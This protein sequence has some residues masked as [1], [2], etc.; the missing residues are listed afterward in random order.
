LSR[1]IG[2]ELDS[3]I[4]EAVARGNDPAEAR[5]AFG[6][7]LRYGEESRNIRVM[8]WLDSLRADAVFGW[9]QL[10]KNKV[11]SGAAI[12]S[13]ALGIGACT[14][15]SRLIDALLLRPLPVADPG[16]LYA[17]S[18][19]GTGSD[20]APNE[21]DSCSYPMFRQWRDA[22]KDR[23]EL[24]AA[25][26]GERMDLTYRSDR[27]M[28]KAH[29]QYV[30]GWMFASFGLRPTLGRLLTERDDLTPDAHPYGVLSYG[31]WAS[32]FAR[33]PGAIGRTFRMGNNL[34]EIVGVGPEG[35]TG[36]EPGIMADIFVPMT[37]VGAR[38]IGSSNSFW[39]RTFVRPKPGVPINPLRG[40]L[41][42]TYRAF[43]RE[44]A[45]TFTNFPKRLLEGYPKDKLLL[46]PAGAG[47]S[48]LQQDYRRALAALG[49]LVALVLLIACA[50]VANLT[51]AQAAARAREMALR[52]SIGAGRW[53]LVQLVLTE[54]ALLAFLAAAAGE[55]FAWRSAPFVVGLINPADNP[56]RLSLP[57]DWRM[58]GF[59]L[60]LA[61]AVML[62]FGLAPALRAS[63]V[64]PVLALKGGDDPR[65]RRRLMHPL[66]ALQVAFC[67][68]VV[69][70][71]GLFV[72]TFERLANQPT[73]FSSDRLLVLETVAP[74]PQ[75]PVYWDQLAGGLR[76]FPGVERIALAAWP[77]L[78]GT[79]SNNFISIN[80]APPSTILTYFLGVS[81][82]WLETMKIP[83]MDGRDFRA[84]DAHPGVAIVNE[85]F[86]EAY[87]DGRDPVGRSFE[88]TAAGPRPRFQIV[89]WVKDA[90][91][92]DMREPMLPVA[93]VPFQS[94]DTAGAWK[95]RSSAAI[96]VR[97]SHSDSLALAPALRQA[98]AQAGH[99]F[100]VGNIRTQ[101][102]INEAHTVRE[103]LLAMLALFF[104]GVA[105]LLAGVGLYGVPDYSVLQRRRE[106]GIRM[107]IGAQVGLIAR[108]VTVEIFT[109]VL[110]GAL[111]GL[112]LGLASVRYIAALLYQVKPADPA[113][114]ALPLLTILAAAL[115]A[116]LPAVFHALRIDPAAMLR[117]E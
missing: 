54:S 30:S 111:A 18:F 90:R 105:L 63:A 48:A 80:G 22:V 24:L 6:S 49:V 91:Y 98:V 76:E 65:A 38:T 28:E 26:Y 53:R 2:E 50:N 39:F 112:A 37:M 33:D 104:A 46:R 74:Q 35:F 86:A 14:A 97:A 64:Q 15:A 102:E 101:K 103:R 60:A 115:L 52:V 95:P 41:Y 57:A 82:G 67:F 29:V 27:E 68:V 89:G 55:L 100:R 79:Q 106:I 83:L 1:D 43:E 81:P 69:F 107:A 84:G 117:A 13:L 96:L 51:T 87:F 36:T 66:I 99:G 5:R 78:S 19:E 108:L 16:R 47:V 72:S 92:Q 11:A 58:V 25:S 7:A 23:A 42:A 116:A 94:V 56:A 10:M 40:K 113:M 8:P 61:F 17:I 110:A 21:Y 31:Y 20:G 73:G 71:S 45:K 88:T 109:M 9:R 4:A 114:L 85:T 62:L 34:Y 44:R 77:L 75:L 32:R 59:G 93:Y 70:I 12:L 3:H